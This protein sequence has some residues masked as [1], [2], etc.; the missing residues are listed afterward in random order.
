[1]EIGNLVRRGSAERVDKE[2]YGLGYLDTAGFM[3]VDRIAAL[4]GRGHGAHRWA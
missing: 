1:M 2:R 3:F 4:Q